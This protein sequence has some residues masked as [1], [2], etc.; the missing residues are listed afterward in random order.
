MISD[1]LREIP[2]VAALEARDGSAIVQGVVHAEQL[3][4]YIDPGKIVETCRF[5]KEE[6]KYTR[7]SGV[8]AVDWFPMEPRFEVVYLLHS[9]ENRKQRLRLK[10][11]VAGEQPEIDSVTSLWRG[12]NWYEREVFDLF[13]IVFR[14]HP[15]LT[16][17]MMPDHWEGHPLRKDFP[18]YGL[19]YTYKDE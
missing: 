19:K 8:T 1:E 15:G 12:A 16:R 13:G 11:R 17:I 5:L 2:V 14:G 6:Q 9:I 18:V 3:A 7:L 10:C 4:L